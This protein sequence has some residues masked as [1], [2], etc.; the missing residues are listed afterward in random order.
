M[1]ADFRVD[2][3]APMRLQPR[4]GAFFIGTHKPAV[5]CDVR[6]ENG[7]QPASYALRGQGGT[8]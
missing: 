7:G 8:P 5:A 4:Q 2:E 3:V 1:F 6:R